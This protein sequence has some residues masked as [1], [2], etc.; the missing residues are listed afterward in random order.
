MLLINVVF[1]LCFRVE[2]VKKK[3][4]L[5]IEVII[6]WCGCLLAK[7]LGLKCSKFKSSM[8]QWSI[9]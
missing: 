9:R 3:Q 2:I 8:C 1:Q 4:N 6:C 7:A 5:L